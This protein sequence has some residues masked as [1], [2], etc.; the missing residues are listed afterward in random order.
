MSQRRVNLGPAVEY[1]I[2]T[3]TQCH[4]VSLT[5]ET[6]GGAGYIEDPEDTYPNYHDAFNLNRLHCLQ[7]SPLMPG[8]LFSQAF[9][10]IQINRTVLKYLSPPPPTV[11]RKSDHSAMAVLLLGEATRP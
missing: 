11:T 10:M 4:L 3:D 2:V 6:A 9:K 5:V 1:S 8:N 7:K